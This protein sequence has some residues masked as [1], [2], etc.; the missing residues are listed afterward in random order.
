MKL[1]AAIA[2]FD[3]LDW[4]SLIPGFPRE[5]DQP[6]MEAAVPRCGIAQSSEFDPTE[7]RKPQIVRSVLLKYRFAM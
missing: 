1:Y 3:A 4:T 5:T 2:L 6:G 7:P